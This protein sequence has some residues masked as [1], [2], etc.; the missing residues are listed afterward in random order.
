MLSIARKHIFLIFWITAIISV[1]FLAMGMH[2]PDH[3]LKPMLVPLLITAIWLRSPESAGRL[4][5]L[6]A[7]FF[8]FLGDVF[9]LMEA[10]S[11]IFFIAGLA[12]FLVTHCCY[13]AYFASIKKRGASLMRKHF[14]IPI[15]IAAY[16]ASLLYLLLPHLDQ[17]KI[18]VSLYAIVISIMLYFSLALPYSINKTARRLFIAGAL[19]F[20]ASDSILAINRFYTALPGAD[21]IIRL[22]YCCAQYF[23]V[24]GFIRKRY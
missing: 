18:P 7:L 15:A 21:I 13:I 24:K 2:L 4:K 16:T 17:L 10:K 8:A 5:I 19:F 3:V 22:T 9:L 11:H 6:A 23:L 12:C 1:A 14:F 20:V